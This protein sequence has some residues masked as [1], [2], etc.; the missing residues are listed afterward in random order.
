VISSIWAPTFTKSTSG[1][2]KHLLNHWQLSQITTMASSQPATAVIRVVS[3]PFVGAAFTNTLNGFGGSNRVP[4]QALSN[5][6]IDKTFRVDAR[7]TKE[8]PITER[9]RLFLNF[10]AFNV[11]NTISNTF[12][13][14]EAYNTGAANSM[15]LTPTPALG[16]GNQSQGFPDGTNARRAQVSMRFVF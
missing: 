5:L 4:F 13:N 6:D 9:F 15:V 10:E 16:N 2:A 12:V 11:F 8:L 7:I 14:T 3:S 1:F